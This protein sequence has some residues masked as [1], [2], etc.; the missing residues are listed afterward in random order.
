MKTLLSSHFYLPTVFPKTEVSLH[1][2]NRIFYARGA[3]QMTMKMTKYQKIEL[4]QISSNEKEVFIDL[5]IT[6]KREKIIQKVKFVRDEDYAWGMKW[7]Y[8]HFAKTKLEMKLIFS[9]AALFLTEELGVNDF[10]IYDKVLEYKVE[11]KEQIEKTIEECWYENDEYYRFL[12]EKKRHKE[13]ADNELMGKSKNTA[14][15]YL[16]SLQKFFT[17][18]FFYERETFPIFSTNEV[19]R[20]VEHLKEIKE[21]KR[22]SA[23]YIVRIYAAIASYAK[24]NNYPL[25]KK[26][27]DLPT[28][29]SVLELEGRSLEE[30]KLRTLNEMFRNAFYEARMNQEERIIPNLSNQRNLFRNWVIF[31]LMAATG[32]RISEVVDLEI[33]DLYLEGSRTESRYVHIRKTKTKIER[34]IPLSQDITKLLKDYIA[35]RKKNDLEIEKQKEYFNQINNRSKLTIE[36]IMNKKEI[37]KYE[38][39]QKKLQKENLSTMEKNAIL[40]ELSM[41]RMEKIDAYIERK[42]KPL[43]YLFISNRNQVVSKNTIMDVFRKKNITSHQL[44]HSLIKKLMDEGVSLNRIQKISGHKTADMILRYST[45]SLKEVSKDLEDHEPKFD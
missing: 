32:M 34:K 23:N 15:T 7:A 17:Y 37:V 8:D 9:Y 25:D 3:I 35:F 43:P 2:L 30:D 24:Y 11:T 20:F 16:D 41:M 22:F 18:L 13:Y 26:K 4:D 14:K 44:R 42:F 21:P 38:S 40:T 29:P 1:K 28:I 6:A 19:S 12:N 33:D 10:I 27:I 39:I 45:P 31:R 36:M 5:V